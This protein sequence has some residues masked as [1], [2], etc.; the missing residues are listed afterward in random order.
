M[1][2]RDVM[3]K[4]VVSLPQ[5]ASLHQ[6]I[7]QFIQYHLDSLPIVDAAER[8]VGFIT[9][10]DL[11]DVFLPRYHEL[12]RDFAALEDKGQLASLFDLSFVGL[13]PIQEKLILAADVMVTKLTWI[14]RDHSLLQAAAQ[15]Q[16]QNYGRLPV[17]DPDQK[18]VGMLSDYDVVLALLQGST[19]PKAVPVK[20]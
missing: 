8:V 10:D 1:R 19:A 4:S 13:D 9:I 18:L 16:I 14:Q 7:Q 12:L 2:V 6:V 3:R 17:V 20:A 5:N 15:L 11:V